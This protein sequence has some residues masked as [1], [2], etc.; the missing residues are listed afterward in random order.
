M[1]VY[2]HQWFK[3]Q[4]YVVISDRDY[5]YILYSSESLGIFDECI[6]ILCAE[7]YYQISQI[8]A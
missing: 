1:A 6:R 4:W 7:I 5:S 8:A 3:L 2:K